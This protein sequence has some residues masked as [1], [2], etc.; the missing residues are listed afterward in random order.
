[1]T[2]IVPAVKSNLVIITPVRDEEQFIESTIQCVA[3]Q[4]VRPRQ[5]VIVDDGSTDRTAVIVE[6]YRALHSWI[7][8][9]RRVNRGFRH[10]GHG[11]MEAFQE[12]LASLQCPDW[13]F[14]VKLDGDLSFADNYFE[15]LL[16]EFEKDKRLGIAGGVLSYSVHGTLR[17]EHCPAFHV[18]GATKIY[19][20]EC[21][22]AIGGLIKAPGWDIVDESKANLHGWITRSFPHATALHHRPTGT[23]ESKWKDQIKNGR[24]YF[25]AGYHPLFLAAKCVYRLASR[26]YLFGSLAMAWGYFSSWSRGNPKQVNDPDLI[27]FVHRQQL[28]RLVGLTTIWK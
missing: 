24:A 11:V 23:A 1:M 9:I 20:R 21:W 7:R 19:R 17:V 26:P 13:H 12:G 25:V 14:L 16:T 8:L 22:D 18:R 6:H 10:S 2:V 4:T 5:W 27:R 3:A 28:R 15:Q